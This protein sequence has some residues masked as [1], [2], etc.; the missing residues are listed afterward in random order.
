MAQNSVPI[1]TL[2]I[3]LFP[4]FETLDAFGPLEMFGMVKE[5]LNTVLISEQKG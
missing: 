1:K 3:L 4:G 5:Q 2:G